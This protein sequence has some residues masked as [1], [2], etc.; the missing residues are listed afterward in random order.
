MFAFT[1]D[2]WREQ[3]YPLDLWIEDCVGKFDQVSLYYIGDR[4]KIFEGIRTDYSNLVLRGIGEPDIEAAPHSSDFCLEYK[5]RAASF[6]QT[7]WIMMLDIDE[8]VN[9]MPSLKY[10]NHA[11]AIQIFIHVLIG[12][13]YHE[14]DPYGSNKDPD[15]NVITNVGAVRWPRLARQGTEIGDWGFRNCLMAPH[16]VIDVYHTTLLRN[17]KEVT[18]RTWLWKR[19]VQFNPR[20]IKEF[21]PGVNMLPT[22]NEKLP[23]IL[24]AHS[25]RFNFMEAK[26]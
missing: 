7:D 1:T 16:P 23:R 20:R 22:N 2:N 8:F 15:G 5:K 14:I 19:N 18:Q 3:Q 25:D 4:K 21:W 12:D 17:P 26:A 10:L 9:T 11:A 13:I 6:L 24:V